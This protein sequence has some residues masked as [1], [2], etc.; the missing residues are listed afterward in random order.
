M[1][2]DSLFYCDMENFQNCGVH[3]E[4]EEFADA[5]KLTKALDVGIFGKD[6]PSV[7]H[8]RKSSEGL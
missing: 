8:T 7:D 5:F 4:T 1:T 3:L 2:T 6:G